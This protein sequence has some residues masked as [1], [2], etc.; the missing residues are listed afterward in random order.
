MCDMGSGVRNTV[1]KFD[2]NHDP[3]LCGDFEHFAVM[4]WYFAGLC[5]SKTTKFSSM[6][7]VC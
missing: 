7:S 4:E 5:G 1:M 6:F 3:Q 2:L